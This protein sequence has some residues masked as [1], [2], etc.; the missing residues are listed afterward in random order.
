MLRDA[1]LHAGASALT[2]VLVTAL[3]LAV[4]WL[5]GPE[6]F[7]RFATLQALGAMLAPLVAL[8]LDT[9][10]AACDS[11][12]DLQEVLAGSVGGALGF[13]FVG[14]TVAAVMCNRPAR[15]GVACLGGGDD[16]RAQL[17]A[18]CL[19]EWLG[20]LGASQPVDSL[21]DRSSGFAGG[22]RLRCSRCEA[23]RGRRGLGLGLSAPSYALLGPG[24][25][26]PFRAH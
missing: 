9:R 21:S 26:C 25:A 23:H 3:G 7:G 19:G 12:T 13:S 2:L 1:L 15:R 22:R 18:G 10:V 8:R 4:A 20:F 16:G 17:L 11:A 14:L 6:A 5:L 24:S